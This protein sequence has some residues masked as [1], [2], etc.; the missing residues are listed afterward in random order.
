MKCTRVSQNG[1]VFWGLRI[2]LF[3]IVVIIRVAAHTGGRGE[4]LLGE[5][6]R[7]QLAIVQRQEVANDSVVQPERA[8][9]LGERGG[10]GA[11]ARDD[12]VALL[13]AADRI[14]EL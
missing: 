11:V 5:L 2:E 14:S 8:L 9:V 13:L 12:V 1:H 3:L 6:R 10:V 7:A 4:L